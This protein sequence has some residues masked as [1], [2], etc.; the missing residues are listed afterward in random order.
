MTIKCKQCNKELE[1][2]KE[3]ES[4]QFAS[5]KCD[6]CYTITHVVEHYTITKGRKNVPS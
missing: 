2:D 4:Q 3:T 1:V 5:V 6:E